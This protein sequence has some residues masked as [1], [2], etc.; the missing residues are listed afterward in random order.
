MLRFQRRMIT[1][2]HVSKFHCN[3]DDVLKLA[4]VDRL[5]ACLSFV[6]KNWSWSG[7]LHKNWDLRSFVAKSFTRSG[8]ESISIMEN[9]RKWGPFYPWSSTY[10][11]SSKLFDLTLCTFHRSKSSN[12]KTRRENKYGVLPYFNLLEKLL[13]YFESF[14]HST[15]KN[16]IEKRKMVAAHERITFHLFWGKRCLNTLFNNCK[17]YRIQTVKALPFCLL[18]P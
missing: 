5:W 13:I 4:C 3:V 1:T 11:S 8:S 16:Y 14:E 2:S 17:I 10:Y 15:K 9:I 7:A 6:E 12:I 18:S